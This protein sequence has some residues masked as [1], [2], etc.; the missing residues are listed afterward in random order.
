MGKYTELAHSIVENVGG[1]ENI[2]DLRHC[3]TRLRFTLKDESKAN[4]EVLDKMD[5]VVSV[6]HS[7]GQY[8][9][10]IG[11]HVPDVYAEVCQVAGL[12]GD[13]TPIDENLDEKNKGIFS[14][15]INII[16]SVFQ[17]IIGFLMAGG[18]VKGITAILVAILGTSFKST[19]TYQILWAIGD[20]IFFFLPFFLGIT[21]AKHW[22]INPMY[23][24]ALAAIM[25]YPSIQSSELVE[26]LTNSLG[27]GAEQVQAIGNIP[28]IGDYYTTFLGIPFFSS[29]YTSS[30]LPIIFIVF[31]ASKVEFI[32]NKYTPRMIKMFFVP[33]IV[34]LVTIPLGL[35]LIGPVIN[36]LSNVI[37]ALLI[38]VSTF[39]PIIYGALMGFLWQVLI[40]FGLHWASAPIA[41]LSYQKYRYDMLLAPFT[42]FS[43][44]AQIGAVIALY[45][46]IKDKNKKAQCIPA[47]ISG[48]F[49]ITE[50]AIYGL[51]LPRKIPFYMSLI[52]ATIT[53]A[54]AGWW[55]LKAYGGGL[56][57]FALTPFANPQTG[58]ASGI[59]FMFIAAFIGLLVSFV[60]T[61]LLYRDKE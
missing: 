49:G 55:Q 61:M 11:N 23:G 34:L 35:L 27:E 19:G 41:F 43:F 51:T 52:G 56:G 18:M 32:A 20:G 57:I 50:P 46:K 24:I 5:G 38:Q 40:V 59:L 39:N 12:D 3:I 1:K 21:A 4:D 48:I 44:F 8:H 26:T 37:V 9:V 58:D 28:F 47:I 54:L 16:A 53:G 36:T 45:F 22:K 7:A 33:L 42:S 25:C 15:M 6:I 10:V 17:P 60:L 14:N 30:A 2:K 29:T 31:L 13:A